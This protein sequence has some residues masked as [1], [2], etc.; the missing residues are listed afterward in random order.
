MGSLRRLTPLSRSFGYDR[1][2]PID[3]HYIERFLQENAHAIAGRVLEVGDAE[4]TRRFG[5]ERVVRSDVLNI[6]AGH[7]DTTFVADLSEG[8][9]L[10][11]DA[12]DC[13]IL[14][15][16]L[17][18]V[19]DLPAAARTLHRILRPGG[20][21]LATFPGISPL[22]SDMWADTWYWSLTPVSARRLFD[23]AFGSEQ[24]E[25]SSHGNVLTSIAFLQGLATHE[26][27]PRELQTADPQFP[28][29]ITVR[30]LRPVRRVADSG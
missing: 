7:P 1:G 30:A 28:M 25:I 29:L 14:T 11:S 27:R 24:V 19:Y 5:G 4:Y 17:H 2:L 18:L 23:D 10:P 22:S 9:S 21:L 20:T 16:T 3:R 15:Q 26:L 13:V 12:F 6:A 8:E